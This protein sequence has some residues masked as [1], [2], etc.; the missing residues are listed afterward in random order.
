MRFK[1]ILGIFILLLFVQVFRLREQYLDVI[2][3]NHFTAREFGVRYSIWNH[4]SKETVLSVGDL[5]GTNTRSADFLENLIPP[6]GNTRAIIIPSIHPLTK[7]DFNPDDILNLIGNANNVVLPD[8]FCIPDWESVKG[9][10][11]FQGTNLH[12]GAFCFSEN[13]TRL[14]DR[15]IKQYHVSR[16]KIYAD[17]KSYVSLIKT[18]CTYLDTIKIPYDIIYP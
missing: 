1:I 3:A 8:N 18:F 14:V 9:H 4:N 2:Q 15:L 13:E 6:K 17:N 7:K 16:V 12:P 5:L 11:W 10:A